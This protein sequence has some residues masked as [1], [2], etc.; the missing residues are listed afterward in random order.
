MSSLMT[1]STCLTEY[2]ELELARFHEVAET[3]FDKRI[4]FIL[5]I[6][7][8]PPLARYSPWIFLSTMSYSASISSSITASYHSLCLDDLVCPSFFGWCLAI[9]RL[10][11]SFKFQSISAKFALGSAQSSHLVRYLQANV[12]HLLFR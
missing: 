12:S 2:F 4:I 1:P 5:A 10:C 3:F 11:T 8:Y 7:Q 9:P 6:L